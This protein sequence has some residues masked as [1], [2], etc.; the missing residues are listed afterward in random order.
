[1]PPSHQW[2]A[3]LAGLAATSALAFAAVVVAVLIDSE[4]RP[5]QPPL[6]TTPPP[7]SGRPQV[8]AQGQ[9][10]SDEMPSLTRVHHIAAMQLRAADRELRHCRS[11]ESLGTSAPAL[12]SWRQCAHPPLAHLGIGA[13]VNAGILYQISG[14]L[15]PG[16]CRRLVLGR[17]NGMRMLATTIDELIRGWWDTAPAGRVATVGRTLA[18]ARTTGDMRLDL[19]HP[20]LRVC[21][22]GALDA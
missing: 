17:A 22:R 14:R 2:L 4:R 20:G 18:V 9:E 7:V 11:T 3:V 5:A 6:A 19:R 21:R 15:P 10:A 8:Q 1:M 16:D 12:A 13:R